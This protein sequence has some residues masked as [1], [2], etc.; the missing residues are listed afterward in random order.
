MLGQVTTAQKLQMG[1]QRVG[2]GIG[3]EQCQQ[4]RMRPERRGIEVRLED[5][6]VFGI[7]EGDRDRAQLQQ[8]VFQRFGLIGGDGESDLQPGHEGLSS[9][10]AESGQ[11]YWSSR[12]GGQ[13]GLPQTVGRGAET[14]RAARRQPL[15]CRA[16]AQCLSI[17]SFFS[18]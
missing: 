5:R 18:R 10:V 4:V 16:G 12:G 15:S 7:H 9:W 17:P 6:L 8:L 2:I 1:E 11:A 13:R 14:T 3:L